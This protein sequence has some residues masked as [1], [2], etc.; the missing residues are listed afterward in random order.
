M[1]L[2]RCKESGKSGWRWGNSGACYT[3]PGA[4]KKAIKQ[5][6]AVT[7]RTGE[8]FEPSAKSQLTEA[9]LDTLA[10]KAISREEEHRD[11]LERNL[12]DRAATLP[13]A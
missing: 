5:G 8:K 4:K 10:D 3:G 6:L 2:E 11:N 1:P 9:Q 7:H 12:M 13:K